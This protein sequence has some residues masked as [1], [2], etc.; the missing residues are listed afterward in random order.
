MS[1]FD[2]ALI[3]D[4]DARR[5]DLEIGADGDLLMDETPI[6]AILISVGL[7]RRAE[8]DDPLPVGRSKFLT[9]ASYSELRGGPC[10]A[11]DPKGE[12]TGAR[13]WLLDRAKETEVTRL[14]FQF[15]LEESLEWAEIETGYP[16]EIDTQWLESNSS[17]GRMGYRILIEDSAINLT[18]AVN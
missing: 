18:R 16:A 13:C 1:F 6:P 11:L 9:P 15:W 4:N 10:D 17:T 3:Y 5:C 14:L 12:R 8:P 7:D 2:A